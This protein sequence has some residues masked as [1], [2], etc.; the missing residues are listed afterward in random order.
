[1]LAARRAEA[2][3][4]TARSCLGAGETVVV[5]TDVT[6]EEEVKLLANRAIER[7]GRID[8]W[9]NNAGVSSFGLLENTPFEP[10]R[11]VFETN[12]Y[13]AIFG[14]RAVLPVFRRQRTGVLI[15][16]GSILS[17]VGQPFVPSYV[18]SK[19]ALRG[20]SE[21]LRSELAEYPAIHVCTLLPYAMNT[22]HFESAPNFVG[23]AAHAL[24]PATT[25]VAAAR[26]MV[27]LVHRPRRERHV[28]RITLLGLA[29]HQL[30]PRI[31]E[32]A[33]HR[34]V[35]NWHF[36]D[37]VL[38]DSKGNL[39]KPASEPAQIAGKRPPRISFARLILWLLFGRESPQRVPALVR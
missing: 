6:V 12:V 29:L 33:I 21:A 11:R 1:M 30:F 36:G 34:I 3:E 17:K 27:A 24:P 26:A 39:W 22:Q 9:I 25:P 14:A 5:V 2:L 35:S 13:G 16:V 15:N 28:P 19:F 37:V 7:Y 4:E 32:R 18:I 23:R 10:H 31:V 20:L 8:V 38:R